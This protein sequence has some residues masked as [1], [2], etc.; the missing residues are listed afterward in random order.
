MPA[1]LR[2][3]ALISGGG[4]TLQNFI[5]KIAVG[6][7]SAEVVGVV[8]SKADVFG[9]ERA[10][11]AGLPVTVVPKA[12]GRREPAVPGFPERVWEAVRGFNPELVCLAGWL[13][14]LP[15]PADFRHKVLNIHPA[16]LPAFGGK[17]MYGHHVHEAVLKY[18]A[19]VSGCTVHFADDTYDTGPILVQRCVPVKEDDTPDTLAARVFTAECEAY[20]EA[21]ELIAAGRVRVE[22]RRVVIS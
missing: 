9:V 6:K 13:H 3:V 10:K 7:L 5:D 2:I 19:K 21:I 12:S 8:S 20:P 16:L 22:G 17:G 4:T 18:G 11:R 14:L 15:I 1:R